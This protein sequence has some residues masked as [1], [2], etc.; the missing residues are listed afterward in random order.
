[1][2]DNP[3]RNYQNLKQ[4]GPVFSSKDEKQRILSEE[5]LKFTVKPELKLRIN[6]NIPGLDRKKQITPLNP[7]SHRLFQRLSV[8]GKEGFVYLWTMP[9]IVRFFTPFICILYLY[10]GG[11][12][13]V[14][15]VYMAKE[16][17]NHEWMTAYPKMQ[18][19]PSHYLEK[20][21]LMA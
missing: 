19:Q 4:I 5:I 2:N 15:Q 8:K 12:T 20:W 17:N 9:N 10:Y 14:Q 1:M 6:M 16:R 3:H 21:S 13:F 11:E 7:G 18:S